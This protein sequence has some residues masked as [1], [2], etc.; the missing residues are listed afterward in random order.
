T[1]RGTG[2]T[3]PGQPDGARQPWPGQVAVFLRGAKSCGDLS[4]HRKMVA[5]R[6]VSPRG[7]GGNFRHCP[8]RLDGPSTTG[9]AMSLSIAAGCEPFTASVPHTVGD[10]HRGT[11][12]FTLDLRHAGRR[13]LEL[14]YEIAGNAGSPVVLVAGGISADRDVVASDAFP[15]PG[16][17]SPQGG[18]GGSL[19]PARRRFPV[20]AWL[21]S[22]GLLDAPSGPADKA[23]AI[24]A[25][26][27]ALVIETLDAFDGCSY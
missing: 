15:Q 9:T 3:T 6:P 1:G 22:D 14:R 12:A 25:L 16:W 7:G 4:V 19:A 23:D 24:G 11:L 10:A 17:W 20:I 26:L 21:G 5:I 13:Q 27:D 8:A 2:P 18:A